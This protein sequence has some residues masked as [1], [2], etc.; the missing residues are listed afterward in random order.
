MQYHTNPPP[1]SFAVNF[2]IPYLIYDQYAGLQS[3]VGFIFG[4]IAALCFAFTYFFVPECKGK[5]LEQVDYMFNEGVP[6]RSF[7]SYVTPELAGS[8]GDKKTQEFVEGKA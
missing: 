7:G 8:G 1:R 4:A 6:L 5:T 2:S 3:K